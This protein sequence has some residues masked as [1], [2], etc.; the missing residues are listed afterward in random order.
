MKIVL[1]LM[2]T[3]LLCNTAL[4]SYPLRCL[5]EV[6]KSPLRI[7]IGNL[8]RPN[9]IVSQAKKVHKLPDAQDIKVIGSVR[10][11]LKV[12]DTK[13][14]KIW[15]LK[16]DFDWHE[17]EKYQLAEIFG[18]N[19]VPHGKIAMEDGKEALI[20]RD[21]DSI[22]NGEILN[23][24]NPGLEAMLVFIAFFGHADLDFEHNYLTRIIGDNKYYFPIDMGEVNPDL[25]LQGVPVKST[26]IFKIFS[27]LDPDNI[28]QCIKYYEGFT[29]ESFRKT[30]IACGFT[31]SDV[32][33]LSKELHKK[34]GIFREYFMT[35]Y[36][37]AFT[38]SNYFVHPNGPYP[39]NEELFTGYIIQRNEGNLF[40]DDYFDELFHLD[41]KSLLFRKLLDSQKSE[42]QEYADSNNPYLQNSLNGIKENMK[43]ALE[44]LEK[45]KPAYKTNFEI[46]QRIEREISKGMI[47]LEKLDRSIANL[48]DYDIKKSAIYK[49]L[50]AMK[51]RL[52]PPHKEALEVTSRDLLLDIIP[53][54]DEVDLVLSLGVR[55]GDK[56]IEIGTAGMP[57]IPLLIYALGGVSTGIE[58]DRDLNKA[59]EEWIEYYMDE[60]DLSRFGG[61]IK[62]VEGDFLSYAKNNIED[63]E[64]RFVICS[65]VLTA[66]RTVARSHIF[67]EI[68]RI[69]QDNGEIVL[70][71]H[72]NSDEEYDEKEITNEVL[73]SSEWKGKVRLEEISS[74]YFRYDSTI[75]TRYKVFKIDKSK[76]EKPQLGQSLSPEVQLP[77]KK[78]TDL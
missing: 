59:A 62:Q 49:K 40:W 47:Y 43:A 18:V 30:L 74:G 20:I 6:R 48:D 51:N 56:A 54:E 16:K 42:I 5:R 67:S 12:V 58:L 66:P 46:N 64:F 1:M 37:R 57:S 65:A 68:L 32:T 22:T 71:H 60:H 31:P 69:V 9:L 21:I 7:P 76:N 55:P 29:V 41:E 4:Y 23:S 61:S 72:A 34:T 26:F 44:Y 17:Y 45:N 36:E 10:S 38:H 33:S 52:L 27:E 24:E 35:M 63:G 75:Y 73:E 15:Y 8:K 28:L 70:G 3:L 25:R 14:N 78:P 13:T 50:N 19:T 11:I 2:G 53:S 77:S 39:D